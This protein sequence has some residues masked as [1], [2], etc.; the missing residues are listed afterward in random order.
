MAAVP[1][2]R[3]SVSQKQDGNRQQ[4]E[5]ISKEERTKEKVGSNVTGWPLKALI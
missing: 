4:Q 5:Y 3:R 2:D 1:V